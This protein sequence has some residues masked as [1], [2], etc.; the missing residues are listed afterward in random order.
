MY[1]WR[2]CGSLQVFTFNSARKSMST[3]IQNEESGGYRLFAKGASEIIVN[4]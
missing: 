2:T 3:L 1:E 4:K